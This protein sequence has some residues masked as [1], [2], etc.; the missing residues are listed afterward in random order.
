[1]ALPIEALKRKGKMKLQ[2]K[3]SLWSLTFKGYKRGLY[4]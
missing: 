3:A 4:E 1:M 2:A